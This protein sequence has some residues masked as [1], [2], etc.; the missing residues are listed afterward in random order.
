MPA[1][2]SQHFVPQHYL[3]Q[4]RI[5]GTKQIGVARVN[6]FTIIPCASISGQCQQDYFYRE[7]G[8]LDEL[9]Q[10][11]EQGIGPVLIRVSQTLQFDAK[12]LVALRLLATIL[13]VR[14]RKAI[15]TAKVFP[16]K[17]AYEV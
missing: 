2:K 3:R 14:T 15:E 5:G 12:E 11:C 8:Q 17:I 9:L 1:N 6:P 10:E 16:K 7:D 13:H 4:F